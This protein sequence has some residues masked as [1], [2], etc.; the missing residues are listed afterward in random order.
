MLRTFKAGIIDDVVKAFD[1][2]HA[3]P[4][5]HAVVER[6]A[7]ALIELILDHVTTN[8]ERQLLANQVGK[9][10]ERRPGTGQT[11]QDQNLR[12]VVLDVLLDMNEVLDTV[13][14]RFVRLSLRRRAPVH[15]CNHHFTEN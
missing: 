3:E 8:H 15:I 6:G 1:L 2:V 7:G 14:S 9:V 11:R 10:D 13:Q 5:I 12:T 4:V